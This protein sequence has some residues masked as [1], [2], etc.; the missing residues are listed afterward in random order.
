MAPLSLP[1]SVATLLIAAGSLFSLVSAASTT[2]VDN[3]SDGDFFQGFEIACGV[4][5]FGGDL[6]ATV[7]TSFEECIVICK[8]TEGCID[9]T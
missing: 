9:G 1:T 7:T 4:D 8:G 3:F 6:A 2:C 5:Y